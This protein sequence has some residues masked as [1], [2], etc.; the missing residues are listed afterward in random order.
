MI[1][2]V[3]N[4]SCLGC[5]NYS[6]L[7]NTGYVHWEQGKEWLTDWL[8]RVSIPDFGIMGGEPLINPECQKWIVGVRNL[9]PDSQIR[10]TTNGLLLHDQWDL[11][12]LMYELGNISFKITVHHETAQLIDFINKMHNRYKWQAVNEY[13]IDRWLTNNNFRFHIKKPVQFI[14]TY[15]NDYNNMLPWNSNPAEAF[16]NCCQQTC[17]LLHQ[18][19]IYKCSTSG[20]LQDTLSKVAPGNLDKWESYIVPGLSKDCTDTELSNFINNFGK[21]HAQCGQCPEKNSDSTI[22][23]YKFVQ[24]KQTGKST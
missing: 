6:D 9:M 3:C 7:K 15:R 1:T 18:G 11:I 17:P 12:D 2:Q 4:L 13:G 8:A 24:L 5:T 10:F 16:K 23:H 21:P 19:K 14:K 20:L 22:D